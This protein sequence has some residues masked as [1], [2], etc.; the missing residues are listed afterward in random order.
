MYV[1][2]YMYVYDTNCFLLLSMQEC[3]FH[4]IGTV[5]VVDETSMLRSNERESH[6]PTLTSCSTYGR[7]SSS[8]FMAI[9]E[10]CE[11]YQGLSVNAEVNSLEVPTSKQGST[12]SDCVKPCK[13]DDK[14]RYSTAWDLPKRH[15]E[16]HVGLKI[17]HTQCTTDLCS[18]DSSGDGGCVN[19]CKD[20]ETLS[21][22]ATHFLTSDSVLKDLS[23]FHVIGDSH[24]QEGCTDS[25]GSSGQNSGSSGNKKQKNS[26]SSSH[27]GSSSSSGQHGT[28][29]GSGR[30]RSGSSDS[31]DDNGDDD[32][33][34]RPRGNGRKEP[35]SKL[36]FP[37]D[38]DDEAT[39]SADEGG[40]DDT[41]RSMTMDC[42]P[43]SQNGS[44][45]T[46]PNKEPPGEL[47]IFDNNKNSSSM[48][49]GGGDGVGSSRGQST[50]AMEPVG[51][52]K[53]V[54]MM[55]TLG[56]PV[57]MAVGYGIPAAPE[58]S[59]LIVMDKAFPDSNPESRTGT[60]T[61]DSPRPLVDGSATPRTP[62]LSPKITSVTQVIY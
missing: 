7:E 8:T 12:L 46:H 54:N 17:P 45:A 47:P 35:K 18:C 49:N 11:Y 25:G 32:K 16:S 29:M 44:R 50:I 37:N 19:D 53:D 56:S 60:P 20:S 62:L 15:S 27:H 48:D 52:D 28:G 4:G 43:Q 33:R 58:S 31:S 38:E 6:Y 21:M 1:Y 39:D 51:Y 34:P 22:E 14:E 30:S 40:C 57:N 2:M 55:G 36:D 10:Y 61:L 13:T 42:S 3:T 5:V 26:S 23:G 59:S 24:H 41:P 9:H